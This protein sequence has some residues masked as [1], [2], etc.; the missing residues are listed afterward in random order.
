MMLVTSGVVLDET[1]VGDYPFNLRLGAALI[2]EDWT[3]LQTGRPLSMESLSVNA[4]GAL[5][6]LLVQ[7]R[8]RMDSKEPDPVRWIGF[9]NVPLTLTAKVVEEDV[10]LGLRSGVTTVMRV[11]DAG[12][13]YHRAKNALGSEPLY[14]PGHRRTLVLTVATPGVAQSVET[15]FADVNVERSAKSVPWA[16]LP[17]ELRTAFETAIRRSDG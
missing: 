7:S 16:E 3:R 11:Q 13:G 14:R 4:R 12:Y 5:M 15:G 9:P 17:A 1:H 2:P 10:V 6:A 8:E